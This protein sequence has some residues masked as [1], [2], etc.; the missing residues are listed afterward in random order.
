MTSS[1]F[2]S[3]QEIATVVQHSNEVGVA[4]HHGYCCHGY[5]YT[6]ISWYV[7]CVLMT[8]NMNG[9]SFIQCHTSIIS[10]TCT[11]LFC[12]FTTCFLSSCELL[13][14]VLIFATQRPVRVVVLRRGEQMVLSLTPQRWAG[15]GLLGYVDTTKTI[16]NSSY[17][18]LSCVGIF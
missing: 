3:L 16:L 17:L 11:Y 9:N 18:L 7:L 2:T 14:I 15:K 4:D 13:T 1:N 5:H 12:I 8:A 10:V 6:Q